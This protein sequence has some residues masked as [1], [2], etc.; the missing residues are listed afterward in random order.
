M[1][2]ICYCH[3]FFLINFIG[4]LYCVIL[5][6]V[7]FLVKFIGNREHEYVTFFYVFLVSVFNELAK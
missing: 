5:L 2:E 3:R 4:I 6:G 1:I 7:Q